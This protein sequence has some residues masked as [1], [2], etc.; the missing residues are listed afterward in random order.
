MPRYRS[1]LARITTVAPVAGYHTA[2]FLGSPPATVPPVLD[3]ALFSAA[4]PSALSPSPRQPPL[5]RSGAQSVASS[6][7]SG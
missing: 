1:G 3:R 5:P 6:S 7:R 4:A 2:Q